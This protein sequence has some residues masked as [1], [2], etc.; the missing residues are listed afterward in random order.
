MNEGRYVCVVP[1]LIRQEWMERE[2]PAT[3][4]AGAKLE[5]AASR[6]MLMAVVCIL[7]S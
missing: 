6:P 2:E 5:V 3:E 7:Q 4:L 1:Y